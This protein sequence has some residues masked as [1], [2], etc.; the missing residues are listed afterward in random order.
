M[1]YMV[2]AT[3]FEED[4]N[5]SGG[6]HDRCWTY[7]TMEE[8]GLKLAHLLLNERQLSTAHVCVPI[9]GT[10][11]EPPN[12]AELTRVVATANQVIEEVACGA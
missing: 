7:G 8:A 12:M 10:D 2:V 9:M 5:W 4:H 11:F 1:T 6:T 3:L